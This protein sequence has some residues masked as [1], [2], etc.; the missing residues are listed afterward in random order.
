VTVPDNSQGP[1]IGIDLGTT[2]SCA[3]VQS[4]AGAPRIVGDA[5][6]ERLIPSIVSFSGEEVLV[7]APAWR[8]A[9]TNPA[10]TI[11]GSKRLIGRKVNA[12]DVSWFARS[13]PFRIV[14][15]PNGDAW[16]RIDGDARS[17]QEIAAYILR[18]VRENAER[19]LG[20]PVTRAVVTVPAHFNDA[21]RQATRDAGT[22]AGLDIVRILNEPTAAAL[23][24]GVH[25]AGTGR[26]VVA[27][28]DL[29]GGTFDISLM[30]VENDLFEVL[31]TSGDSA[32]GGDDWD[33]RIVERLAD[34][35]FDAHRLDV[36]SVP[37]SL[38]RLREAAEQ[39]KRDLS[40]QSETV[41][42]LPYL[43]QTDDGRPLNI[44]RTLR[45]DELE[46]MTSDLTERLAIPC[47]RALA[48]A[49]LSPGQVDQVLLVGGMTR[50]PAVQ[51]LV[52]EVFE[53]VPSKNENPDEVV[54]RGAAAHAAI[55]AG[56]LD[57]ATLLDVTSHTISI[58]VGGQKLVPIIPRN[59]MLPVRT[60]KLFA[61]TTDDQRFVRIEVYQGETDDPS[62]SRKLGQVT[63]DD[64]PAGAAGAVRV[65]L[66][67]TIDVESIL[68][69]TARER[70]TGREA[71][72]RISPSGGLTETEIL[73]IIERRREEAAQA[74]K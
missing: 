63:L 43:A 73:K 67:M 10:R 24:Y 49:G 6:G 47:R 8:Q 39:A 34:E 16:I 38:G 46:A 69:I 42:R 35:I 41:L 44:E 31:A 50:M 70:S 40:G 61:T 71:R 4:G 45:R 7:G 26:R 12:D 59:S 74:P 55:L 56:Q 33:R 5:A 53:R 30:A 17:P 27:V 60:R 28:F 11:F 72:V 15:A 64:L 37:V 18:R 54:A 57:D 3:A 65:E 9:I 68:R 32:L 13:S 36:T 29:G 21:Q 25:R 2:N 52:E 51:A 20:Q 19:E 23:A 66:I 22:I 62:T 14:A 58:R 1:I 48:D